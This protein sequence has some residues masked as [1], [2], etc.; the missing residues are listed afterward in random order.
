M[1]PRADRILHARWAVPVTCD[2]IEN[3]RIAIRAGRIAAIESGGLREPSEIDLGDVVVLPGFVNAHTHLELTTCRG[4]VP[5]RGSFIDWI[6]RLVVENPHKEH[7][8]AVG[9]SVQAGF[10][11]SL[12]AGVTAVADIGCGQ[13]VVDAW[14]CSPLHTIGFIEVLG[15]DEHCRERLP[16]YRLTSTAAEMCERADRATADG[17]KGP[18]HR[19]RRFGISPHAPYSTRECIYREAIAFARCTSR[20]ICTHL[21]ETRE[22]EQF[23]REGTGPFRQMLEDLGLWDGS[24]RPP[25]CSPVEFAHEMGLLSCEALLAHVNYASDS[26]LDLLKA[27]PASVVYCPRSHAFFEHE[28]HRYREMLARGINVCIGTDS[29]ASNETLSILDELRHLRRTDAVTAHHE[30][31]TMA[32]IA[33]ARALHLDDEIGSLEAGKRAD[34]AVVPLENAGARDPVEDLLCG[35]AQMRECH[36][37]GSRVAPVPEG[38][39]PGSTGLW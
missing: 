35:G 16:A 2:P 32:T 20:P 8:D 22:E 9:R 25:G 18:G 34:L 33:G 13:P 28:P 31:L 24:F 11:Q 17:T 6:R 5:Y 30:L 1:S 29:L 4:R 10:A 37:G 19:I 14:M 38:H 3:A 27:S 12:A 15:I 7:G 26:D 39:D 23:V 36:P 21:A